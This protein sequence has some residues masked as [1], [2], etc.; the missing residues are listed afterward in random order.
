[1]ECVWENSKSLC[2]AGLVSIEL[3]TESTK[4]KIEAKRPM[5]LR[6]LEPIFADGTLRLSAVLEIDGEEPFTIWFEIPQEFADFATRSAEPFLLGALFKAMERGGDLH[7]HGNV[8]QSLLRNLTEYQAA[9]HEWLPERYSIVRLTAES[10]QEL[11]REKS[12]G[13]SIVAF[14]GGVDSSY[15]TYRHCKIEQAPDKRNIEAGLLIHGFDIPL[16]QKIEF[17]RAAQVAKESLASL[18]VRL[19][20]MRSNL[21]C[22]DWDNTHGAAVAACLMTLQGR[23]EEGLIA[24]TYSYSEFHGPWGSNPT[25]DHLLSSQSFPIF[26]DGAGTT[27]GDKLE[28]IARWSAG[29]HNLRVCWSA[30][31]RDKNCGVCVKC[32][33]TLFLC[34]SHHLPVPKSFP[35]DF[36][37]QDILSLNKLTRNNGWTFVDTAERLKQSDLP[38][39]PWIEAFYRC[40]YFNKRRLELLD[41]KKGLKE[42]WRKIHLAFHEWLG[43]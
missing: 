39:E 3:A 43:P 21:F 36:T 22:P 23:Y 9:W 7:V 15:T 13:L 6:P 5:Q 18:H 14:T 28:A 27:R 35:R 17:D 30:P 37:P 40:A 38:N 25:T 2:G 10:S 12:T 8:A 1:M 26:H 31:E 20:T 19:I 4:T 16:E 42:S 24:S 11:K 32:V 41:T 34:R 33:F 29:F